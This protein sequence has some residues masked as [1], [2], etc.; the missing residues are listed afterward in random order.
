[1]KKVFLNIKNLIF[2]IRPYWKY[3]KIYMMGLLFFSAI[4]T[5]IKSTVSVLFTQTIIDAVEVGTP[6]NNI[7]LI[8]FY[9]LSFNAITLVFNQLFNSLYAEKKL[10][11]INQ[12]INL[13]IYNKIIVTDYKYFDDPTF[14]DSYTWSVNEY[15]TK[16]KEAVNL[17]NNVF[18]A[19]MTIIYMLTF[20]AILGPWIILISVVQITVSTLIEMKRNKFN[21]KNERKTFH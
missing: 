13:E 7:L 10:I 9:F 1:M 12:Q 15:T 4:L 18:Q 3:G 19:L 16:S 5:P 11:E 17:L 21:I 2:L 20:I 8:I 14:Y 6:F